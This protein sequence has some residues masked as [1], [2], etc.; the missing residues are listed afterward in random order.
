MNG[1]YLTSAG[2]ILII[3]ALTMHG[4]SFENRQFVAKDSLKLNNTINTYLIRL[5]I[6]LFCPLLLNA[7]ECSIYQI[8]Q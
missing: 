5:N 3:V 4:S 6:I 2:F 1:K 8:Y 7:C